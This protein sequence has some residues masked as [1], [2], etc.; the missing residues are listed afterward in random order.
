MERKN[1]NGIF[2]GDVVFDIIASDKLDGA[3]DDASLSLND[4]LY[5]RNIKHREI[6][7]SDEITNESAEDFLAAIREINRQDYGVP[8]GKRTPIRVFVDS[9]G[10]GVIAGLAVIDTIRASKTP[11]YTI[12]VSRAYSMA[13]QVFVSGHKRFAFKNSSFLIHDGTEGGYDSS[14][15]F[16]DRMSFFDDLD[17]ACRAIVLDRTKIDEETF[18]RNARHEWYILVPRAI[19]LGIVDEVVENFDEICNFSLGA[20]SATVKCTDKK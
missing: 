6:W 3:L 10:G 1:K 17:K 18:E 12:N 19:E 13:F 9:P 5:L 15:K 16:R 7:L 11:I 8:I 4:S 2:R 20:R 14:N